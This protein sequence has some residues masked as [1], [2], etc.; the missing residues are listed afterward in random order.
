MKPRFGKNHGFT[1]IELLVVIAII[2]ILSSVVLASLN[3]ARESSRDARRLSDLKQL[4]LALELHYDADGSYPA[5]LT[6]AEIVE[7]GYIATMPQDPTDGTTYFYTQQEGGDSYHLG[8]SLENQ[9]HGQLDSDVDASSAN[10]Q[11]SDDS[12]C[13]NEGDR[14]CY[15]IQP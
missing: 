11:G 5:E 14:A 10:V 2:G 15:D 6:A 1:L 9:D 4:Q 7:P 3:T 12:G 13:G 8:A